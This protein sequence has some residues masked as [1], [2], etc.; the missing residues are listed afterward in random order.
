MADIFLSY[1]REDEARAAAVAQALTDLGWSV[2]W[3]RR[4]KA[5]TSWD[6]V[7]ERELQASKCVV[8]L[9]SAASAGSRWVRTEASY[10]LQ[11][12]TL[13]PANLDQ[14][15]PPLAFRFLESAQLHTWAGTADH[16]EFSV[17]FEGI[18][19]HVPPGS[20][21]PNP[22]PTAVPVAPNPPASQPP[23]TSSVAAERV[24]GSAQAFQRPSSSSV[25]AEGVEGSASRSA[26]GKTQR[27]P[28]APQ[29]PRPM[30][31]HAAPASQAR[32]QT[33]TPT[34]PSPLASQ[35]RST[36]SATI[37]E[38]EGTATDD[39]PSEGVALRTVGK[40]AATWLAL[41]AVAELVSALTYNSLLGIVVVFGGAGILSTTSYESASARR[42]T[43]RQAAM[44]WG[45]WLI[46][47]VLAARFVPYDRYLSHI[48]IGEGA[49]PVAVLLALCG[50]AT[51]L[52]LGYV[53]QFALG[54]GVASVLL[55]IV[56]PAIAP[57]SFQD[58]AVVSRGLVLLAVLAATA[59]T[60]CERAMA[61]LRQADAPTAEARTQD[62]PAQ[63]LPQ[64]A[65]LDSAWKHAAAWIA[66][67]ITA[68]LASFYADSVL[69]L[70]DPLLA[71]VVVFGGAGI[72]STIDAPSVFSERLNANRTAMIWA[73]WVAGSLV[74]PAV[75]NALPL[76]L[77]SGGPGYFDF[78]RADLSHFLMLSYFAVAVAVLLAFCG[79]VTG[80]LLGR[81]SVFAMNWGIASV[82]LAIV[83][84]LIAPDN[85]YDWV[86]IS[87]GLVILAAVGCFATARCELGTELFHSAGSADVGSVNE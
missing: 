67:V 2:F 48:L 39:A 72:L 62:S 47:A 81:L 22:P 71:I 9:W 57:D 50:V 30:A 58:W 13:V 75:A 29:A 42:L 18:A 49:V 41:V 86:L 15:E 28:R 63:T 83:P 20:Q 17:L 76:G 73:C 8:V 40:H 27:A 53:Q 10:G 26:K 74:V 6:D 77:S 78:Y 34:A 33:A 85:F 1:A 11:R 56:G 65:L 66:L 37:E 61:G 4:I 59:T 55:A 36:S 69:G 32:N 43:G 35:S 12:N 38:V 23:S 14:T 60:I 64:Q 70:G 54:W 46:G 44:I 82:V 45:C 3:D 51:G 24:E 31:H 21:G 84:P 52:T 68:E 80:M 25:G 79:T 19:Q 5:G 87:R 16:P 7:V